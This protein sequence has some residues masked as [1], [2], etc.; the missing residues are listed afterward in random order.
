LND[1]L[2]KRSK[3]ISDL[4]MVEAHRNI[5]TFKALLTI[6]LIIAITAA[7]SY[8]HIIWHLSIIG[9][10]IATFGFFF[11]SRIIVSSGVISSGAAFYFTNLDIGF[12]SSSVF[13]FVGMLI[14]LYASIVYLQEM[15]K[16]DQIRKIWE[17]ET[18]DMMREYN[19]QWR[20]KAMER[21]ALAFIL[22]TI[23]FFV[24]WTARFDFWIEMDNTL[25]LGVSIGL[26]LSILT[27]LYILFLKLPETHINKEA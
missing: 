12:H 26:I 13:L 14:F 8:P 3:T 2:D 23:A 18:K 9:G 24:S 10:G 25:L 4:L 17:G 20:R 19:G 6:I 1:E 5:S 21:F 16:K 11:K 27:I 22:A 15:M 7:A